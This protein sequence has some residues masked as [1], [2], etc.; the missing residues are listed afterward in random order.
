MTDIKNASGEVERFEQQK[1]C[2]SLQKAGAPPDLVNK[3]CQRVEHEVVEGATTEDIFKRAYHYLAKENLAAAARYRLRRALMDLGPAGFLFEQYIEAILRQYGYKTKRDVI[4]KGHCVAHE[5]DIL[6]NSDSAH[7]FIEA[8]YHNERGLKTDVKTVMYMYARIL[9]I[10]KAEE[11]RELR[12]LHGYKAHG[13]E[14]SRRRKFGSF[15]S[16]KKPVSCN[17]VKIYG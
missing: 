4:V 12:R 7:Y 10:A 2:N 1:L 16:Q 5:I 8:K 14:L 11:S 15:D 17:R 9:D 3:V 13:M 6:A